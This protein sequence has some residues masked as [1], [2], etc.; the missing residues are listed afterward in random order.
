MVCEYTYAIGDLRDGSDSRAGN[1]A[2]GNLR[3]GGNSRAGD[4]TVGDLGN[5]AASGLAIRLNARGRGTTGGSANDV[6]VDWRALLGVEHVLIVQVVKVSAQAAVELVV[7]TEG[8]V[9]VGADGPAGSVDGAG[10]R[11]A[12]ELELRVGGDVAGAVLGVGEHAVGQADR[13]DLGL[14][15]MSC[16]RIHCLLLISY[17][18]FRA[19]QKLT[20]W[21]ERFVSASETFTIWML[22]VPS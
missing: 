14:T 13:E 3:N 19:S 5:G 6:D 15:L 2:V 4:L 8:Q 22:N 10:L 18:L 7:V 21:I 12:V 17:A 9:A 20:F 1:L 11:R 16:V